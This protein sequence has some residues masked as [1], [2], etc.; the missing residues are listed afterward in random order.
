MSCERI[1]PLLPLLALDAADSD[2]TRAARGHVSG[3][4]RC[5]AAL[6]ELEATRANLD[7]FTVADSPATDAAEI[8]AAFVADPAR[9]GP[10]ARRRLHWTWKAAAAALLVGATAGFA[11]TH[12]SV[13]LDRG[14][15]T[16]RLAWGANERA[17]GLDLDEREDSIEPEAVATVLVELERR[18]DQLERRHERDL[19]LLAQTV[20]RQ[21]ESRERGVSRRIDSLEEAT[22]DGFLFTNSVLDG[23][24]RR[25]AKP[26]D[27]TGVAAPANP[28]N[29]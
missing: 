25:L 21:Q 17:P 20:D 23:V 3:C 18:V 2:E 10:A 27:A 24:A 15:A 12:G 22:H 8:R 14:A 16:L 19:L 5:G 28:A 13:T 1:L 9:A 26:A 4:E 11:W 29:H 7:A 6:R